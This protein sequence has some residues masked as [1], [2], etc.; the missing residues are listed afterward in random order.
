MHL[1]TIGLMV[2][3]ELVSLTALFKIWNAI[4]YHW[5]KVHTGGQ[6]LCEIFGTSEIIGQQIKKS[7]GELASASGRH[8]LPGIVDPTELRALWWPAADQKIR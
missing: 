8:L 6:L 1:A 3:V 5:S 2:S 4:A 7:V